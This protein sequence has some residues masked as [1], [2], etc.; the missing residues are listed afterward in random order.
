MKNLSKIFSLALALCLALT[1]VACGTK[2]STDYTKY[3][4]LGEYKGLTVTE[5]SVEVTA[6][7]LQSAIDSEIANSTK[8]EEVTDR[9]VQDGDIATIDYA[10]YI[11]GEQF[12]G[13][14]A[15][16]QEIIVG[17]TTMIDGFVEGFIGLKAGESVS[18]DLTFPEDYYEDLAGKAVKFDITVKKIEV[19]VVPEYD[20]EFCKSLGYNSKE[21]YENALKAEL[22]AYNQQNAL[23]E[24]QNEVWSAIVENC[25]VTGYP[26]S[27][28][29][30]YVNKTTD[31]YKSYCESMGISLEE[32]LSTYYGMTVADFN[33]EILSMAQSYVADEMILKLIAKEEGLEVSKEEYDEEVSLYSEQYGMT[34]SEF[35]EYYGHD[36]IESNILW[37]KITNFAIEN[38]AK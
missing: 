23:Y 36:M 32:F 30:D 26:E 2:E 25:E 9:G 4:K 10:G 20:E 28:I 13:G 38:A 31:E 5:I 19:E 11:D 15:Q 6:E 35:E 17:T 29:D 14:T 34:A 33:A 22:L 37:E 7:D 8:R 18:L 12:D 1:F 24:M 21:E 16:D 27:K 3:V